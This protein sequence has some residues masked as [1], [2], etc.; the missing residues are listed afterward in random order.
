M[1]ITKGTIAMVTPRG[2]D[3]RLAIGINAN[4]CSYLACNYRA[5]PHW[6]SSHGGC[7]PSERT[8]VALGGLVGGPFTRPYK[9]SDLAMLTIS[10]DAMPVL[11]VW[12]P[13]TCRFNSCLLRNDQPGHW[14]TAEGGCANQNTPAVQV[15]TFSLDEAA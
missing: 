7:L 9:H 15:E 13:G 10:E 12:M 4:E 3:P 5:H 14:H 2:G 8:A 11:A 6:H 1:N